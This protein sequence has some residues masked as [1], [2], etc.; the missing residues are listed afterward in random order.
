MHQYVM[1][2]MWVMKLTPGSQSYLTV[3]VC[4]RCRLALCLHQYLLLSLDKHASKY[5]KLADNLITLQCCDPFLLPTCHPSVVLFMYTCVKQVC[6]RY[7][8]FLRVFLQ[9]PQPDRQ[10]MRRGW[11]TF[12][13]TVNIKEICW[14][15]NNIRVKRQWCFVSQCT[16]LAQKYTITYDHIIVNF[17]KICWKLK[18]V[19]LYVYQLISADIYYFH[20]LFT[21]SSLYIS[22]VI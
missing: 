12:D 19:V 8:G 13:N 14:N 4:C 7:P 1:L 11:L 9:D 20:F 21:V 2:T 10:F 15:L 3:V 22:T 16:T 17:L 6:R 5:W 18:V